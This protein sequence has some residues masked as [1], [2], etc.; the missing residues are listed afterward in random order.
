MHT[1]HLVIGLALSLLLP[2]V[3][4]GDNTGALVPLD[5]NI[6]DRIIDLFNQGRANVDPEGANIQ[7][8][9]STKTSSSDARNGQA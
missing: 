3:H 7:R 6:Q 5:S 9:V 4:S 1:L 2:V 8:V